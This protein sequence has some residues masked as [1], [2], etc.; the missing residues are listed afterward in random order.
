MMK[1]LARSKVFWL[2]AAYACILAVALVFSLQV[3]HYECT[4]EDIEQIPKLNPVKPD[5]WLQEMGMEDQITLVLY[6]DSKPTDD[7]I[8]QLEHL[9][10]TIK[11]HSW[12]P[13]VG[14]HPLGFYYASCKVVDLCKLL[15]V[16]FIERIASGMGG[17]IPDLTE[18]CATFDPEYCNHDEDCVCRQYRGCFMGNKGYYENCINET[19]KCTVS[20]L[21]MCD[22]EQCRCVNN[23]C[24]CG[25]GFNES[26]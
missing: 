15:D 17:Y 1:K 19:R 21:D 12:C 13:P 11:R 3:E 4:L 9:G 22:H 2:A 26:K 14:S 7:Q 20:C 24:D 6:F 10:I 8:E 5:I 18:E 16:Q 23:S 25:I